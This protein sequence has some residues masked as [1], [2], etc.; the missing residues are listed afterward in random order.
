MPSYKK[1]SNLSPAVV[2][3]IK[4]AEEFMNSEG[5]EGVTVEPEKTDDDSVSCIVRMPVRMMQGYTIAAKVDPKGAEAKWNK[6][7][8]DA[9]AKLQPTT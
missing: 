1:K 4:L 9:L 2:Q 7:L 8:Q 6:I 5:S 3:N